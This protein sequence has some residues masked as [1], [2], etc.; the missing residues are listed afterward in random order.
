MTSDKTFAETLQ[1]D[2]T[3]QYNDQIQ[4]LKRERDAWKGQVKGAET[5]IELL[6]KQVGISE[7]LNSS[8][9]S[10][11]KW[12]LPKRTSKQRGT[13][14]FML[15]DLHLDE[16]VRPE[17][18]QGSNAFNRDI[19]LM[20]LEKAVTQVPVLAKQYLSGYEYD[21]AVLLLGGDIFSGIIHDEFVELNE[22]PILASLDFWLDPLA[23]VVELMAEEFKRLLV[24]C[25]FGNHG[26]TSPHKRYKGAAQ[27]NFDWFLYKQLER[28]F[29][30]DDRIE[31][32]IP[33]APDAYFNIYG[34]QHVLT[35]GNQASGG[36]GIS[37]LLTP[38]SLL[39][40]RKRKRDSSIPSLGVSTHMFCGHFH[41][42]LTMGTITINGSLKGYDDYAWAHNFP[43]EVP[44]QAFAV[45]TPEH[46]ITFPAPIFCALDRKKEGW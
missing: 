20:R 10:A 26:R 31:W 21:G 27:N 29:R 3:Q 41:Q 23:G 7:Y 40:H 32:N 8:V 44:Q 25:E 24:V 9:I 30:N 12:A 38:L 16:V 5:Q 18:I 46:N 4:K 28:H 35:H 6:R 37:G 13:V 43:F 36:S 2:D 19:A 34:Y 22:A 14:L 15:S 42:Y 45:I 39:D 17:E 33:D 11:P 1:S